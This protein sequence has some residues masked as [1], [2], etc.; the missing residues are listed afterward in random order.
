MHNNGTKFTGVHSQLTCMHCGLLVDLD[1]H[2]M[3]VEFEAIS[4]SHGTISQAWHRHCFDEF[5]SQGEET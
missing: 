2:D 4:L 1:S 3:I 5:L